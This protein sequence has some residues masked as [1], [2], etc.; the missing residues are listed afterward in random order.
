MAVESETWGRRNTNASSARS[1]STNGDGQGHGNRKTQHPEV[2]AEFLAEAQKHLSARSFARYRHVINFS[3]R[4]STASLTRLFWKP[5]PN[6]STGCTT[7]KVMRTASS[8]RSSDQRGVLPR[9]GNEEARRLCRAGPAYDGARVG[10]EQ[11]RIPIAVSVRWYIVVRI[12]T[13]DGSRSLILLYL[14]K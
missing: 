14:L 4:A 1:G 2:L 13:P 3:S 6:S 11:P 5:T 8:A 9:L 12:E 7:P 10:I